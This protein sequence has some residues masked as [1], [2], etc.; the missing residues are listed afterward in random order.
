MA[1][2]WAWLLVV[3]VQHWLLLTSV[4]GD[5]RK[6]LTKACD[7]IRKFAVCLAVGIT[8]IAGIRHAI[9]LIR[10]ATHNTVRQNKR[11]KP[12]T[13]DLLYDVE[14]LEYSLT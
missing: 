8:D 7:A 12:S 10:R 14:L 11:K 4:W 5:R 2:V 13:F 3:I 6:S 1:K 9:E